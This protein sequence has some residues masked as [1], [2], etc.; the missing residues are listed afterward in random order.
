M[1]DSMPHMDD[2][3]LRQ[4]EEREEFLNSGR[5]VGLSLKLYAVMPFKLANA[6]GSVTLLEVR[7]MRYAAG[8]CG[9]CLGRIAHI[10][11]DINGSKAELE[12][13]PQPRIF[14]YKELKM[15]LGDADIDFGTAYLVID[16]G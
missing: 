10:R 1:R 16:E 4:I 11:L 14:Q 15:A 5:G 7:N 2:D 8:G 12:V 6:S 3:E 13:G 9:N